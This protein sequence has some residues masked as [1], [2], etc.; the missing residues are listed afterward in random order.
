[1]WLIILVT[2]PVI[3]VWLVH[4][5]KYIRGLASW[6]KK[7]LPFTWGKPFNCVFC[8]TTWG[9]FFGFMHFTDWAT[10]ILTSLGSGGYA[11]LIE[12]QV[13]FKIRK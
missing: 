6:T 2:A 8:L 10:L 1:M 5:N 13:G 3:G 7:K 12:N 9:V 4:T 11:F